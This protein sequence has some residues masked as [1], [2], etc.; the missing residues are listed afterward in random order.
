MVRGINS[1]TDQAQD[2]VTAQ[3]L[4]ADAAIQVK[5]SADDTKN[6]TVFIREIASQTNLLGLNA[7]IEAALERESW[8]WDLASLQVKCGNWLITVRRP[9]KY[10]R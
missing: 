1:I 5:S 10:R 2:L 4:S 8:D 9:R 3:E 7:A 6:I